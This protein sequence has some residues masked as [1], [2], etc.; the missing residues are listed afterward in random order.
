MGDAPELPLEDLEPDRQE[1]ERF[2]KNLQ[3]AETDRSQNVDVERPMISRS[4]KEVSLL[5]LYFI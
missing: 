2:S 5:I 3:N 1:P 4:R